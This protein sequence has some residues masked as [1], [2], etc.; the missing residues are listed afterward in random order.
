MTNEMTLLIISVV[1]EVIILLFGTFFTLWIKGVLKNI[2]DQGNRIDGVEAKQDEM[3]KNYLDR[4]EK[5]NTNIH[6]TSNRIMSKL[7]KTGE[8]LSKKIDNVKDNLYKEKK[9]ELN[10]I[11]ARKRR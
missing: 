3:E 5:V 9:E 6:D 10:T 8:D 1:A 11:K 4:F 2:S 7:E